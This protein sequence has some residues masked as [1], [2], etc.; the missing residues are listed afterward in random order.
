MKKKPEKTGGFPPLRRFEQWK[1]LSSET[2]NRQ[3]FSES[4][5]RVFR[6]FSAHVFSLSV[7][8][9]LPLKTAAGGTPRPWNGN[10]FSQRINEFNLNGLP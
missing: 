1:S 2:P 6:C 10:G 3:A 7:K 5:K 9:R 8:T 4:V